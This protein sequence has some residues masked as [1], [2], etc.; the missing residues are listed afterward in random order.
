MA[1]TLLKVIP[2]VYH[3]L[4]TW[5]IMQNA[6]KNLGPLLKDGSHLLKDFKACMYEY[7]EEDKFQ[8]AWN[9]IVSLLQ[10]EDNSWLKSIYKVKEKWAKCYMRNVYTLGVRSTQLT[11]SLNWDLKDYLKSYLDLIQFFKHFE[12]IVED[13]RYNELKEEY[14]SR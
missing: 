5:H 7:E 8:L 14:D 4:C 2:E 9:Q 3:G 1:S 11:E 12:R 10:V 13:K 6:I